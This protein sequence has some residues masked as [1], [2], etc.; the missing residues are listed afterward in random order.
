[1]Q[2]NKNLEGMKNGFQAA[3]TVFVKEPKRSKPTVKAERNARIA[4]H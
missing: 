2:L 3:I 4:E 1:M